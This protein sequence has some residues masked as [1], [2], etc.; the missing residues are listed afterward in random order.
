MPFVPITRTF[1]VTHV[2]VVTIFTEKFATP[3]HHAMR[4][5]ILVKT[6]RSVK[7]QEIFNQPSVT[8]KKV[9]LATLAPTNTF[10]GRSLA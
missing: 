8:V 10:A 4:S 3:L 7:I 2:N 9:I 6:E 5:T 1:R